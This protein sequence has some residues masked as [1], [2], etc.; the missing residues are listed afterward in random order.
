MTGAKKDFYGMPPG[1]MSTRFGTLAVVIASAVGCSRGDHIAPPEP[2]P[3]SHP[4]VK[5]TAQERPEGTAS[6]PAQASSEG[7]TA[8]PD[9]QTS[10]PEASAKCVFPL[11]PPPPPKAKPAANC[12]LPPSLTVPLTRGS[13]TFVDAKK[14]P[15][16]TVELALEPEDQQQGLMYR[17][18]LE[19]DTGMLF[20]WQDERIRTFWMHNTCIPL[21]MLFLS[22][23][24]TIVGILE[25]VPVLNDAPRS[26][27]CPAAHVLEVRAGYSRQHGIVPGMRLQI[28]SGKPSTHTP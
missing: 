12:P 10:A 25:E 23:D 2:E 18:L 17:T 27:P 11:E 28:E 3:L 14:K 7:R 8:S 19:P 24:A 15:R 5:G 22:K 16:I 9:V 4:Q 20:T 21:D 1:L 13:V 6:A 26:V